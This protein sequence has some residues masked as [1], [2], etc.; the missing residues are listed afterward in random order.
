MAKCFILDV[1]SIMNFDR[2]VWII[3]RTNPSIPILR[4]DESEFNMIK[5]NIYVSQNNKIYFNGKSYFV[6]K[7]LLESIKVKSKISNFN[8]TDLSFSMREYLDPEIIDN[9]KPTIDITPLTELKN[10]IGDTY[11]VV[12]KF[13]KSKYEKHI[14]NLMGKL[15][16]GGFKISGLYWLEQEFYNFDLDVNTYKKQLILMSHITGHKIKEGK[17]IQDEYPK[18]DNIYY[19]DSSESVIGDLMEIEAAIIDLVNKSDISLDLET[20]LLLK[21]ITT[22][23]LNRVVSVDINLEIKAGK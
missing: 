16:E 10:E 9:L 20:E 4:I 18:Y 5:S 19:Y 1:E 13:M 11:L 17:L 3:N 23:K 12:S 22:N 8:I 6:S 2:K 14:H 15:S 7:E 21:R